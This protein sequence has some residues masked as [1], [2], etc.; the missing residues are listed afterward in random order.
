[1]SRF[2]GGVRYQGV[3]MGRFSDQGKRWVGLWVGLG[4]SN[5]SS[6]SR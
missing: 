6:K 2:R 5:L 1:M 4:I 3:E